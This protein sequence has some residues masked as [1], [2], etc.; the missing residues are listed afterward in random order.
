MDI[1]PLG[2]MAGVV[3]SLQLFIRLC[4]DVP[5]SVESLLVELDSMKTILSEIADSCSSLSPSSPSPLNNCAFQQTTQVCRATTG[6][7]LE[8]MK[9][10]EVPSLSRGNK[11]TTA[12]KLRYHPE[13]VDRLRAKLSIYSTK[14]RM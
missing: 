2:A 12:C 11:F 4:I 7:L 1:L 9:R 10:L 3:S 13:N 14:L 5:A 8:C 6:E